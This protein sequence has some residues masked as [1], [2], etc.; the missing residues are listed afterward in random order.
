MK[1]TIKDKEGWVT[2]FEYNKDFG[3]LEITQ[4]NAEINEDRYVCLTTKKERELL[5]KV[6]ESSNKEM[7]K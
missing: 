6:I 5:T 1:K 2:K 4:R 7:K 3:T